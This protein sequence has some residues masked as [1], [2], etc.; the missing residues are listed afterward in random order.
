[1]L[2]VMRIRHQYQIPLADLF[3]RG[4]VP[5]L[6]GRV[7]VRF[8]ILEP[9][10]VWAQGT[11]VPQTSGGS[12]CAPPQ[13]ARASPCVRE[14]D[15]SIY[16][17]FRRSIIYQLIVDTLYLFHLHHFISQSCTFQ[18][19]ARYPASKGIELFDCGWC[20]GKRDLFIVAA[21]T[22]KFC[23]FG[24]CQRVQNTVRRNP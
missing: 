14:S 4:L 1:M 19:R 11:P 8:Q 10:S 7:R 17:N 15:S 9:S 23:N 5:R 22:Q 16:P 6:L 3:E 24:M 2:T 20:E 12:A 18:Y 21:V 13:P